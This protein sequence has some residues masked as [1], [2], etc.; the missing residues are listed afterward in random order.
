MRTDF[1][2]FKLK[3]E[4]SLLSIRV[5]RNKYISKNRYL[6]CSL[7]I[8]FRKIADTYT[9]FCSE[10]QVNLS[11]SKLKGHHLI[12]CNVRW[13]VL[14]RLLSLMSVGGFTLSLTNSAIFVHSTNIRYGRN[15]NGIFNGFQ[16]ILRGRTTIS[17]SS[18][19]C[20]STLTKSKLTYEYN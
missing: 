3:I 5:T 14:I 6:W 16:M 9:G 13:I 11:F 19:R 17:I 1:S 18:S 7:I 2:L 8:N 12:S 20:S 15:I 4:A 10:L